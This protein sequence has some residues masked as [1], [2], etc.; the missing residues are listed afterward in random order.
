MEAKKLPSSP[1][2]TETDNP[3]VTKLAFR[4]NAS[5]EVT[6]TVSEGPGPQ[7]KTYTAFY[8]VPNDGETHQVVVEIAD[9]KGSREVYNA[10]HEPGTF[11]DYTFEYYGSGQMNILLDGL[12]VDNED[13]D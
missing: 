7:A 8:M 13:L 4:L 11:V 3:D 2:F 1:Q 10:T 12:V 6:I 5:G 9:S